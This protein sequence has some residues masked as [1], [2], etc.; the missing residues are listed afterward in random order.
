MLDL[1]MIRQDPERIRQALQ[2][3][4]EEAPLDELLAM[5][6]RRRS[7][8]VEVE[9]LKAKRNSVSEEIARLK[10]EKQD[11]QSLVEEMRLVSQQ[12]KEMD[13]EVRDVEAALED[14][15]LRIPNIPHESV[16]VGTSEADNKEIRRWGE[17]RAFDFEPQ[18][19]WDLGVNLDI[20]DFERAAKITGSR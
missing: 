14:L 9:Q 13:A 5:D 11:A 7:I 19:H 8:L 1:R 16:H 17:P 12:I 18:P 10:R 20:L 4:G 3:R 6:E 2:N 15:L